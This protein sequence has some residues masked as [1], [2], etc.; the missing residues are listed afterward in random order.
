MFMYKPEL[1]NADDDEAEGAIEREV[2]ED[3]DAGPVYEVAEN[4]IDIGEV[5]VSLAETDFCC[6]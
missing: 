1:A 3:D 6:C 5:A 4:I 2:D